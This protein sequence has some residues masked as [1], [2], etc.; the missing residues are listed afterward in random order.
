MTF[1]H[2]DADGKPHMVDVGGKTATVREAVARARVVFPPDVYA[3]LREADGNTRKGSITGIAHIAGI[4]GAKQT[5]NLIPLCHPLPLDK[6]G[7]DFA[8][9]D[10][11]R[12]MIITA[13]CRVT[14]KTGVEME[15]LT[16]ASV[17]ALTVYDMTKA[18]SHEIVIER[19][20]L[21]GKSGGKRDFTKS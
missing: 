21:L 12:A 14:H 16:A 4:V 17:A 5:A 20:E 10:A 9:D 11:A 19:I 13:T 2:L 7:L 18:M 3:A 8:Y 6:V 15:A 1:S